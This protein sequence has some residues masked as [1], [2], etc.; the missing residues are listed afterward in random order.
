MPI[1]EYKCSKCKKEFEVLIFNLSEKVEC[2]FCGS[3]KVKRMF[4]TFGIG[5]KDSSSGNSK[6]DG[7]SCGGCSGGS[8]STCH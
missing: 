6:G 2:K 1:Y 7:S 4:S 3:K 8:C 5:G